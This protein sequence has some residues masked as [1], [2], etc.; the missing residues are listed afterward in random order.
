MKKFAALLIG[1]ANAGGS[2]GD[3][4]FVPPIMATYTLI[5]GK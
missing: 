3:A 1:I 4:V 5:T 2:G